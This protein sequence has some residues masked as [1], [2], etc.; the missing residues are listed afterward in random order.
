MVSKKQILNVLSEVI[1]PEL[2]MGIVDIGLIY[3]VDI[4]K[5]K[6][7]EMQKVFIKMTF[8]TPACPMITEMLN[9]VKTKLDVFTD[10][11]IEVNVIFDPPWTI[12]RMSNRAKI[13]LGLL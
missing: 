10:L 2:G 7:G 4:A 8:T 9:E 1:D 6:K 13:K 12:D 11:D 3:D 5:K